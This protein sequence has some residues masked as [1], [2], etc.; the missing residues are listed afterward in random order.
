MMNQSSSNIDI[1]KENIQETEIF[2]QICFQKNQR[3][4][5]NKT[6]IATN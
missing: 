6:E 1:I 4:M 2:Y 3:T 5:P